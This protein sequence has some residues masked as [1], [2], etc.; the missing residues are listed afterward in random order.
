MDTYKARYQRD[1][2]RR[3]PFPGDDPDMRP[4]EAV[5]KAPERLT[6]PKIE[7]F[8]RNTYTGQ[9]LAPCSSYA[10]LIGLEGR[11]RAD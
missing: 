8:A 9:Y 10:C 11:G 6:L 7:W 3:L 1:F 5:G 4:K 2:L